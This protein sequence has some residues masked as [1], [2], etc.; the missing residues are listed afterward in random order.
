M[1][2]KGLGRAPRNQRRGPLPRLLVRVVELFSF[3][4]FIRPEKT[5]N[6]VSSVPPAVHGS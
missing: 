4:L 6:P 1:S 3:L 2:C 5:S